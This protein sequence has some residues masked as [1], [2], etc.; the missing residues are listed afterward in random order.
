M[1]I[2]EQVQFS[3]R[4][5]NRRRFMHHVSAAAVAAGTLSFRDVISLQAEELKKR[6]RSMILLWMAGGPSQ[7]EMFDPKPDHKNS[8]ETTSIDTSVSGIQ[9]A[10]AWEKTATIMDDLAIIRSMTSKEGNHRRATYTAH[11]GYAPSGSVKHPSLAANIAYRIADEE[12]SIPSVVSVGKTVGASYLGVDY[13]PFVINNPGVL[14]ENTSPLVPE[15]RF[16]RRM[17]LLGRLESGFAKQGAESLVKSHQSLYKKTQNMITSPDL[18]AFDISS[19]SDEV[20]TSYGKNKF[21]KGCLLARRLIEAGSTFVEVQMGGW[22]T[23]TDVF[24]RTANQAGQV[25]PA[26]AAL[27]TDLKERG[28]LETTTVV[29]MGEFGR[30]PKINPRGGRDHFPRVFNLAMAGGGVKGGQVIG[31][32]SKDG[33]EVQERPV[34]IPDLYNSICHS[35]ELDPT[36]ETMSPLGRPMAIV[37]GGETVSELFA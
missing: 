25:D 22:D 31:S 9:I 21:G 34:T 12:V 24:E 6:N 26:F 8:G 11:T 1:T 20:Q 4:G 7:L 17:G 14:P 13:D 36:D 27:V 37:E 16:D 23:H 30:T 32:S 10:H 18:Q 3:R 35:M 19:E 5:L 29:L 33:Q 28:L 2:H 15:K